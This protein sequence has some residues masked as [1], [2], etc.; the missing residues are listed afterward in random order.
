MENQ[1]FGKTILIT[2]ASNGLGRMCA[3]SFES[4]GANLII[5]GRN[6]DQLDKLQSGFSRP[7]EHTLFEGD[8]AEPSKVDELASLAKTKK[9]IDVI[10][11]V[12]GG[13]LGKREPLIAHE[14]FD[15]LFRTNLGSGAE[16]NRHL[17]PMMVDHGCGHVLHV[18]SVA[19]EQ[20]VASVGYNS[21]KAALAAYVRSLGRELASTGV[22]VTGI[23]PGGYQA[24][25]NSW[26]RLKEKSPEVVEN[27]ISEKQPRGKLGSYKEIIPLIEFLCSENATMMTGC[28]VPID[29]GEGITYAG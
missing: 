5:C 12:M 27:F 22:V 13:G 3:K 29:G 10:L 7:D 9:R 16:L 11:H 28:C 25:G 17:I 15:L 18:G 19:S 14:D 8:L 21:V 6:R 20:A 4:K 2:G 26:E 1:F 24:P 23:L